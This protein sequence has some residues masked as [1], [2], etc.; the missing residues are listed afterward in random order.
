VAYSCPAR[1][2]PT[3]DSEASVVQQ[4]SDGDQLRDVKTFWRRI[5]CDGTERSA[6]VRF[7]PSVG[8]GLVD[9]HGAE[10]LM[11]NGKTVLV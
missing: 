1:F 3:K 5:G 10:A 11:G 8:V 9:D 7:H 6:T 4:Q 2:Q